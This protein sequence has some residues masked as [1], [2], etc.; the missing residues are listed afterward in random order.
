MQH[1][2]L[3]LLGDW[4]MAHLD[5]GCPE[6]PT[7]SRHSQQEPGISRQQ[8]H[9]T[10]TRSHLQ[11]IINCCFRLDSVAMHEGFKGKVAVVCPLFPT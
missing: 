1:M 6:G 10:H 11:I 4:E 3:L 8:G 7:S 9:D 5:V 2:L